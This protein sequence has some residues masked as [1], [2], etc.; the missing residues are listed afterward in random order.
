MGF[1]GY[2]AQYAGVVVLGAAVGFSELVSRYKDRP[3]KAGKSGPG[4]LYITVNGA[5]SAAALGLIL[6]YG[7]KFGAKGDAVVPTRLLV[8]SFGSMALF[9]SALFTVR[10]GNSD[11][12]VGPSTFLS[13]ILAACD[14]GVDRERGQ[15]RATMAKELMSDVD[16]AKAEL[17]LPTVALGLMQNLDPAD[18][19]ALGV[20]L[21]KIQQQT[22]L[23]DRT[24]SL[25]LGLELSTVV[26]PDVLR[27]AKETLG[28]QIIRATTGD[29][30]AGGEHDDALPELEGP[31]ALERPAGR[32]LPATPQTPG[33]P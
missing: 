18:Q 12:G 22:K 15:D 9:R 33:G 20:Q 30:G 1:W 25:L 24:K 31:N 23:S 29:G 28:D 19:A 32:G 2:F 4:L 26:G 21:D 14:R 17:A 11:V 16:F 7:W 5:A 3:W 8:A 10:L 13:L 6:T 27:K